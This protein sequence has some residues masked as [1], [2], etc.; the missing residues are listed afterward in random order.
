M[1]PASVNREL[2]C[3]KHIFTKAQEWNKI[4]FNPA[5]RVKLYKEDNNRVRCL[6]DEEIG[7]LIEN[8]PEFLKPM[9]I[10]SIHT[11][12]RKGELLNLKWSDIDFSHGLITVNET[13]S[14]ES[15][16]IEMNYFLTE[17]L[18]TYRMTRVGKDGY[19][20]VDEK[21]KRYSPHGIMK[22]AFKRTLKK[23][24]IEDFR[25]H[26]MRHVFASRLAMQGT[27]IIA[28]M[29]LLGHKSLK[30]TRRYSNISSDYK[31]KAVEGICSGI[32]NIWTPTNNEQGSKK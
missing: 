8:C 11:G 10:T 27:N 2:A 5:K 15:R 21:G 31:R 3:L 26:D 20:F 32:D 30:M 9:V 24:G 6:S 22:G 25:W 23:A 12:M 16:K 19:V 13:K 18:K 4:D 7:L 14:G 1:T 29:E 28:I 17:T